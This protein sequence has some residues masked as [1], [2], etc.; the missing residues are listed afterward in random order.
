MPSFPPSAALKEVRRK[1]SDSIEQLIAIDLGNGVTSYI[2]GN[3]AK[4]S[5]AS[6]V[7]EAKGTQGLGAGFAREAFK[8]KD[9]SYYVGDDCREAG[10]VVRSTDSSYYGSTEIRVLF[11]KVLKEVSVKN[12]IIVTGLPTEFFNSHRDEFAA[13]LKRWA[14]DE[15]YQPTKIQI[16]PQYA[17]PWFD[18]ELLDES[19]NKVDPSFVLKGKIAIGDIGYGTSDFGQF[20]NGRVSDLRYGESLGVSDIH[21]TL[22]TQLANPD[23]LN[24]LI[25]SPKSKLPKDFRL[26]LQTSVFTMDKWL[27]DGAIPWRGEMIPIEPISLPAR[28]KFADDVLPRAI[29]TLWG[30]TDF[31]NGFIFAGGGSMVLGTELLKKHIFTKI[32]RAAD[33]ENSVVRGFYRFYVTQFFKTHAVVQHGR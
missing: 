26:D 3:G 31:L 32:L 10:A 29:K 21:K 22:F 18:P 8:L 30:S 17:G 20:D 15:G 5:F 23:S 2:A 12:P 27:R 16:L 11:L 28:T 4:G 19:G 25:K 13:T 1:M 7:S 33:P 14:L 6:L 24:D 9:G